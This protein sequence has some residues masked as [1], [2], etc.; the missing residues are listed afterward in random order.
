MPTPRPALARF[1][2]RLLRFA[3]LLAAAFV[4]LQTAQ[5]A[6]AEPPQHRYFKT[7]DGLRLHYIEAG[8]GPETLVFVPGWMM[9]AEVFTRQI[10]GLSKQYRVIAFDPRSQGLS[11]VSK[12]SH[13][14]AVRNRDLRELLQ[15]VNPGP[16]LLAG[17]SLGVLEVLDFLARSN[18]ENLAGIVLIDN[19]IGFGVPPSS[20][21]A[22]APSHSPEERASRLRAFARSLTKKALPTPLF[23]AIHR[24]ALQVPESVARELVQKPYPRQYWRSALLKQKVPVLYAVRP[25]YEV[26]GREFETERPA[27][28]TTVLFPKA[29][30]ALFLDDAPRFNQTVLDFARHAFSQTGSRSKK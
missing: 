26:Q 23:E 10:S 24:S 29:G 5:P 22:P 2:E 30:H 1:Q 19:S 20:R 28:A 13:S 15:S 3:I 4:L 11:T 7:S 27:L 8:S 16:F 25:Q 21:S 9:P 14:P 18:P 12:G 17:W 6:F